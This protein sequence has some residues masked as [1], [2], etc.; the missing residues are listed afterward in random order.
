MRRAW[1]ATLFCA[2]PIAAQQPT[3]TSPAAASPYA[4][5]AGVVV[6]SIHGGALRGA[7]VVVSGTDRSATVDST[8]RF[9]IDSI[10]P[11]YYEIGVFHPLLDSLNLSIST[12]SV[13]LPAGVVTS[14]V[15]ATPSAA[16]TVAAYCSEPERQR[17]PAV[18]IGRVLTA[19]TDQPI[20]DATVRYTSASIEVDKTAGLKHNTF[21]REEAVKATGEFALCGLPATGGGTVRATRGQI[22]TGER[23]ADVSTR[24]LAIVTLRLDT[25]K[26]GT[27]VVIGQIVDE[28]GTPIPHADVTLAGSRSTTATGESGSFALRDLPAGSQTIQVRKVGFV[29][30]DTALTLSS[31][32]PVQVAMTLHAA[33]V[34]LNTVDVQAKRLVALQRVGFERRRQKGIGH[35]LTGDDIRKR[36]KGR[37]SDVARTVPGLLVRY[38]ESGLPVIVQGR[39]ATNS[40]TGCINYLLDG[41]PYLDR[42][43][44]TIDGLVKSEDIIALEV[45]EPSEVP[46]DLTVSQ[47]GSSSCTL[48]VIWT[49][50]TSGGD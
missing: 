33:A 35:Y 38:T 30:V 19:D 13:L 2:P 48:V 23:V 34:T 37:F 32:S 8:G 50:A 3:A 18:V 27:S 26:R 43:P 46:A 39:G 1:V 12:K 4:A 15:M 44:G 29:A 20:K 49:R 24:L 41:N 21:T 11:G 6:D 42:P 10:P 25:L 47:A 36:G 28:K 17:G 45:Y 40:L 5:L 14:V 7:M 22:V 31:R 16:S 9:Q